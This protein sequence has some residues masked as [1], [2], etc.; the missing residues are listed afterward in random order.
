M[1]LNT[2]SH[3]AY[4]HSLRVPDASETNH[5]ASIQA[6]RASE[7]DQQY[8]DRPDNS[9]CHGAATK[10]QAAYRGHRK[11]RQL[12]GLALDPSRRWSEAIREWQ[13]RRAA[14]PEDDITDAPYDAKAPPDRRRSST[15]VARQKWRRLAWIAEHAVHDDA[16]SPADRG[17]SVST[18]SA[19]R[20]S[21]SSG[22]P[23]AAQHSMLLDQRYFLEMVDHMHRHGANLQMYHEYWQ[24]DATTE[25]FFHWLDHGAGRD[26]SLPLCDRQTLNAERVKYLSSAERKAY[27]VLVDD[28]GLLSW[29]KNGELVDTDATKF[30]DSINGIVPLDAPD[31]LF[32]FED[33][34][35]VGEQSTESRPVEGHVT[36]TQSPAS[37]QAHSPHKADQLNRPSAKVV[38]NLPS[39]HRHRPSPATLLNHLLRA[40]V[41]PSTWIYVCS[42]SGTLYVSLKT[43]G[44][45]QHASFLS[46]GRIASAGSIAVSEGKL[47]YL[48]PLSGHY[49]PTT[50]SFKEFRHG[51][52][53][54]GVEMKDVRVSRAI[55]VLKAIEVYSGV[56]GGLR[57]SLHPHDRGT[58]TGSRGQSDGG[59]RAQQ[60][61][62][63]L[64]EM[65]GVSATQLIQTHWEREHGGSR[66]R[67]AKSLG[68]VGG[69]G[70]TA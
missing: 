50:L 64:Q 46:G 4:L 24:R 13:Y 18:S 56:K 6:R 66:V 26:L 20:R 38:H 28:Q 59:S 69:R 35:E 11:R 31:P 42:P 43:P 41:K 37:S 67:R 40:S 15:D 22:V 10:I 57:K 2:T 33:V 25:N 21:S 14:K 55:N 48:S 36:R 47:T 39:K 52:E 53:N 60:V 45:F 8:H 61:H 54:R 68:A 70:S 34:E 51:L 30:R 9:D 49:R 12:G 5:I 44:S 65:E 23:Q 16:A 17:A 27:A 58:P 7:I 1:D 3:E 32:E 63:L 29:A 62:D 19:S